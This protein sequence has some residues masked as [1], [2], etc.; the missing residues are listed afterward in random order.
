MLIIKEEKM[1]KR[2]RICHGRKGSKK[3]FC[4]YVVRDK[5]GKYT[6]VQNIHRSVTRDAATIAKR[7]FPKSK[8]GYGHLGDYKRR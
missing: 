1:S 7:L 5:H 6:D 8:S 2:N 4:V 3:R